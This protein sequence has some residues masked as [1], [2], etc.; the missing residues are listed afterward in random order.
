MQIRRR[1]VYFNSR[2]LL[3]YISLVAPIRRHQLESMSSLQ[4]GDQECLRT[5]HQ[6]N[7]QARTESDHCYRQ[8][9]RIELKLVLACQRRTIS[10]A[11]SY[12]MYLRQNFSPPAYHFLDLEIINRIMFFLRLV[13]KLGMNFSSPKA[14]D[15]RRRKL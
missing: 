13:G 12:F 4:G 11:R 7:C 5:C 3:Q 6:G 9:S 1:G 15:R 10:A 14:A 2:G 8:G